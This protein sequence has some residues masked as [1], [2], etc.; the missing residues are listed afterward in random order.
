MTVIL[1]PRFLGG[2]AT[3]SRAP[4]K[5]DDGEPTAEA[6]QTKDLER[7]AKHCEHAFADVQVAKAVLADAQNHV[8]QCQGELAKAELFWERRQEEFNKAASERPGVPCQP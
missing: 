1:L 4:Y 7:L 3:E 2:R 5:F 6:A 8:V